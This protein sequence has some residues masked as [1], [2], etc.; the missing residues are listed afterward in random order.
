MYLF[1]IH[2]RPHGGTANMSSTFEYCLREGILGV[3]WRT[4]SDNCTK[5]WDEYYH[6][7]SQLH[8]NLQVC[9]YIHKWVGPDDLVW[10][11]DPFGQY[12]LAHVLSG[13]EYWTTDESRQQNIDIANIFR[14][15]LKRVD[16]DE[17]PGKIVACFRATRAIQEIADD[18]AR[19]YSRYLWN[20]LS[21]SELYQIDSNKYS[22]IFMML[23]A[24]ETEDLVFLY[25]Q[26]K[27]WYVVPHSRKGDT[28]TF[29]YLCVNPLN[30]QV[31]AIQVKTGNTALNKDDYVKYPHKI[32]LF[33]SNNIY[34]G[35]GAEHVEII[36]KIEMESFLRASE[37]WLPK[38]F[39][40]KIE[41]VNQMKSQPATRADSSPLGCS[42]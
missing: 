34:L 2:I 30:A 27:G 6:E 24:E 39:K 9:K 10:T 35:I 14:C 15:E 3:G 21:G 11:R 13:W 40:R 28:M 37:Q 41:I 18:K 29:E 17:V 5:I 16:I 26:N 23:D 8:N 33:Q 19:E 36:P 42:G 1:R 22:D 38:S 12:Y 4:R 31:A 20:V 7:A 25:L 32:F